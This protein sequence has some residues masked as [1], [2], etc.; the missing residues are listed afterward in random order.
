MLAFKFVDKSR[1][2]K[3]A[4]EAPKECP[5]TKTLASGYYDLIF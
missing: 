5:V 1:A 4:R 2:N 3:V